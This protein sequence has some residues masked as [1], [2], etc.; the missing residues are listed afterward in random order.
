MDGAQHGITL[1][2]PDPKTLIEPISVDEIR[3][4]VSTRLR[5]WADRA[6]Q[7][8]DPEWNLPLSHKAYV[9]EMMCRAMYTLSCGNI[10]SK[11]FAVAW[12]LDAFPEP[13][14]SL[15]DLYQDW[16]TDAATPEPSIILE[17]R[18]FVHWAASHAGLA[19]Q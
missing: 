5:N 3:K 16:R 7:S 14:R 9:V 1:T 13:W 6:N 2:G 11:Q 10:C 15:V 17:V 19:A 4:A 12:A 8:D 18:R